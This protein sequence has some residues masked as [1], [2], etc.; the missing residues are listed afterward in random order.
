MKLVGTI[1]IAVVL[2]P[3]LSTAESDSKRSPIAGPYLGQS[4]PGTEPQLLGPDLIPTD[5][6]QHCFPAFSPD[7]LEVYWMQIVFEDERP[8]GEIRFMKQDGDR[9]T[10]PWVAPFSGEFSDHAPVFSSD[11]RRLYFSSSRPDGGDGRSNLWYV[12]R[13]DSRWSEPKPLGSPPN[14]ELGAT[15]PSFTLDGT[16]Y[17]V[18]KYEGTQWNKAVYCSRFVDGVYQEPEVIDEPIRTLHADIYPFIAPD[19]SYLIFGSTR[20]GGNSVETDL[21]ISFRDSSGAW[22]N[23][24]HMSESINNG[25]SVSFP[26]VTHDGNYLLFNRFDDAASPEDTTGTDRFFWID[27]RIIE[28]HRP[29]SQIRNGDQE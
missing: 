13:S 18:G 26:F 9:W 17:F 27:A 3:L 6:I 1:L 2:L 12:E 20:P 14:S 10:P 28:A 23:P 16:V 29:G 4:P 8:R 22:G 25:R 19:E 5:G 11:G 21:Y 24:V 15:Q 7:G